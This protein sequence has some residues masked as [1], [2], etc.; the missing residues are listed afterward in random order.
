M[1]NPVNRNH[2][3]PRGSEDDGYPSI[4]E[5]SL[6]PPGSGG[7]IVS[8]QLDFLDRG[9][10]AG[11]LQ[12]SEFYR[13]CLRPVI[14][15]RVKASDLKAAY[16]EWAVN[17]DR[18]SLSAKELSRLMERRGHRRLR[19]NGVRYL[20]VTF[21]PGG[22]LPALNPLVEDATALVLGALG[23]QGDRERRSR[24]A[25]LDLGHQV[26]ALVS[27]MQR[28]RLAIEAAIDA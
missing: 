7:R 28:L 3:N 13:S 14:G 4:L 1:A 20:D 24:T 26:D 16:S 10:I 27:Q 23:R 11:E 15:E 25:L 22:G 2:G 21:C 9:A 12:F 8:V 18:G 5:A 19:S 6:P 17:Y